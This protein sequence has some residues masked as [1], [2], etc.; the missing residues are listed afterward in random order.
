MVYLSREKT[1]ILDA[2][3][4]FLANSSSFGVVKHLRTDN[5][6]EFKSSNFQS[7]MTKNKTK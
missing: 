7:L 3:E 4:I 1:D 5:G 6:T 2:K